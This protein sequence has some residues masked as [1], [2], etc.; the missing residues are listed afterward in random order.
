MSKTTRALLQSR[1]LRTETR[2]A[3]GVIEVR[4][5]SKVFRS[6][7]HR[8]RTNPFLLE[9]PP[10]PSQ[11]IWGCESPRC[12]DGKVNLGQWVPYICIRVLRALRGGCLVSFARLQSRGEIPLPR[13]ANS[14]DWGS[15]FLFLLPFFKLGRYIGAHS[16]LA[17]FRRSGEGFPVGPREPFIHQLCAPRLKCFICRYCRS[18]RPITARPTHELLIS[19]A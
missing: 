1:P 15:S 17:P 12:I 2:L 10:S 16:T 11:T 3:C 9:P 14:G 4:L 5:I 6:L 7:Q 13:N 8:A 18:R 19:T